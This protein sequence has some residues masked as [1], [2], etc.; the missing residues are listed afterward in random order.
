[1]AHEIEHENT[2]LKNHFGDLDASCSQ[3][4]RTRSKAPTLGPQWAPRLQFLGHKLQFLAHKLAKSGPQAVMGC[5]IWATN[6]QFSGH[7][8]QVM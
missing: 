4:I 2:K 6:L 1:M 5:N 3:P 7:N 8:A